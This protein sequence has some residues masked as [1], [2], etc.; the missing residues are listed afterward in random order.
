MRSP[1]HQF[2]EA[3]APFDNHHRRAVEQLIQA[4]R[5]CIARAFQPVQIHV[6][7]SRRRTVFV[8]QRKG[9]TGDLLW[10]RRAQT[11]HDALGQRGLA[12]AQVADQQHGRARRQRPRQA[13]A[14]GDG[15]LLRG[16]AENGHTPP[17]PPEDSAADR[18][19]S[20]ISR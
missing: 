18:S 12:R 17:G 10:R 19:R 3:L 15:L 16:G 13:L 8:D 2:G 11:V 20:G 14:Q 4:Q 9:G 7:D 6:I 5:G 1:R